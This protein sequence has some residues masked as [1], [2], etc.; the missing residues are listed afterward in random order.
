MRLSLA[1]V[2]TV[3][4]AQSKTLD[5]FDGKHGW[6]V[7]FTIAVHVSVDILN[8]SALFSTLSA[9]KKG[10]QKYVLRECSRLLSVL[11]PA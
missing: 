3:Y 11:T 6:T 10:F 2:I 8:T 7:I 4:M 5:V 9:R 1:V